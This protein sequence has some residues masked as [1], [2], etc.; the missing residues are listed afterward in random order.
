MTVTDRKRQREKESETERERLR[1][2]G[3]DRRRGEK[4]EGK[5]NTERDDTFYYF[6]AR[7]LIF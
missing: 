4:T 1:E 2:T 6:G 5:S 3:R 7:K